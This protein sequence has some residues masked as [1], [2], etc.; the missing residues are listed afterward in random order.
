[1]DG[2]AARADPKRASGASFEEGA[3]IVDRPP[4]ESGAVLLVTVLAGA[5]C[6]RNRPECRHQGPSV[7]RYCR[8]K[9]GHLAPIS[10][11]RAHAFNALQ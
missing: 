10:L 4:V 3:P 1:M 11:W 9:Q 6:R 7:W 8:G 5:E 2:D